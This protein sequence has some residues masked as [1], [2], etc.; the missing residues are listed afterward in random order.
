MIVHT[1]RF[2]FRE[3][4]TAADREQVL[5]LM[6]RT[7][8]VDSVSFATVGRTVVSDPDSGYTHAYCVGIADLDALERYMYDPVHLAGDPEIIPHLAKLHI[9]PDVSD[10]PDPDLSAKILAINDRK[11]AAHPEWAELMGTI[12]EVRFG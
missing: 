4:A 8:A 11:L 9:G 3:E 7:A 10:D 6:R 1:L 12:P 5:T 2:A